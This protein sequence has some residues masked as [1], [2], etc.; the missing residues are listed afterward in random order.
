MHQIWICGILK[1]IFNPTFRNDL[2]AF[3][4]LSKSILL[5]VAGNIP[6]STFHQVSRLQCLPLPHLF[7]NRRHQAVLAFLICYIWSTCFWFLLS[8]ATAV[9]VQVVIS[10]RHLDGLRLLVLLILVTLIILAHLCGLLFTEGLGHRRRRPV[11]PQ[12]N[13]AFL[14]L[15]RSTC[16]IRS[17]LSVWWSGIGTLA[18][19][20]GFEVLR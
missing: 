13:I 4:L 1:L 5:L 10:Q 9:L 14:Q 2:I 8:L 18:F 3:Q 19:I 16:L 17:A 11:I 6:T 12:R 20:I 7:A 15:G